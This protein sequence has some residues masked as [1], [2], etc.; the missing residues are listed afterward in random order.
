M[1][2]KREEIIRVAE[3]MTLEEAII[4]SDFLRK[5]EEIRSRFRCRLDQC[6]QSDHEAVC[7]ERRIFLQERED[8]LCETRHRLKL[9]EK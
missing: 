2:S 3:T 4:F 8:L 5:L 1:Q 9:P 7:K 6:D